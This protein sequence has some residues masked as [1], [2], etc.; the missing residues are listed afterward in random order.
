MDQPFT[1]KVCK[2]IERFQKQ[3]FLVIE[4]EVTCKRI[5]WVRQNQPKITGSS[6]ISPRQA[7]ELLF[8]EYMHLAREDLPVVAETDRQITW[9]S[10]NQCPTLEACQAVNL[11]T[12]LV[13]RAVFETPTQAFLTELDPQ[14]KF[15]RSYAEIRPYAGHCQE[16][17]IRMDVD[18]DKLLSN[19]TILTFQPED[20]PEVKRLVL[21]GL[22]EHWG[23]IDNSK[24][25]DL[26][27]IVEN[28]KEATFLVAR[29][30]NRVIAA[31]ALVPRQDRKAEVVRMSVAVDIRRMGIGRLILDQLV[32]RARAAGYQQVILETTAAWLEVI[33]FYLRY[34]FHITYYQDGDVY[35]ALDLDC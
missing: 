8:F 16:S 17:I 19:L 7:F 27:D 11:D 32:L 29:L 35:F 23:K 21:S 5:D 34:G 9:L 15:S 26:D 3:D 28:Y 1:E 6:P 24:N 4:R 25:P 13:C 14:L 31:G 30:H 22:G 33:E 12:R 10:K 2:Q 20:Q 18:N